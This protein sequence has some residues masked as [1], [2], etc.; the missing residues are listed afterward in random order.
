MSNVDCYRREVL[1]AFTWHDT[2]VLNVRDFNEYRNIMMINT[3][4]INPPDA[5]PAMT[6]VLKVVSGV[7]VNNEDIRFGV[8]D[9][10]FV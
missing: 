1:Y 7:V 9:T 5:I 2:I 3:M 10:F 8:V 6:P 4:S